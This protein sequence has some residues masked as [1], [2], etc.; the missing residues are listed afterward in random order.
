MPKDDVAIRPF[1]SE[2]DYCGMID[3]FRG[4]TDEQ[5]L[6]MG[7][8]RGKLPSRQAWFESAWRDQ[9]RAENDPERDRFYLAW[10]LN[11]ENVGHSSINRIHW[12]DSAH[13]HLHL[14]R[15]DLRSAGIGTEFFRRSI[16][17][18]FDRFELQRVVV[19]PNADNSAPN[20]VLAKLGFEFVTRY[21]TVPGPVNFEQTVTRWEIDR[22]TWQRNHPRQG[23]TEGE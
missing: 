6:V 5:L 19:E 20:R 11:G 9:Q 16:S 8:D 23:P 15:P 12:G 14:W 1:E 3:Y 7:V 4:C 10:L 17:F 21:R 2:A 22:A 18:Y 13:A